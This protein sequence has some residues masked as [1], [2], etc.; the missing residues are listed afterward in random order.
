MIIGKG[1]I[2]EDQVEGITGR[3]RSE[4]VGI[5]L[6]DLALG[7]D[8]QVSQVSAEKTQDLAGIFNMDRLSGP[9]GNSFN[10]D[11][12]RTCKDIENPAGRNLI[13]K[14]VEKGLS[15]PGAHRA[16]NETFGNPKGSTFQG[17]TAQADVSVARQG[18]AI[19]V[20]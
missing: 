15:N 10:S 16:H 6:I 9:S 17:S 13:L 12:S 20:P 7:F 4:P 19:P 18:V 2:D 8:S 5:A 11:R 3:L 14:T 1:W